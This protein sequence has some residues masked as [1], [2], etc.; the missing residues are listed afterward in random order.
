VGFN[1]DSDPM[2]D[3]DDNPN[4]SSVYFFGSLLR[5]ESSLAASR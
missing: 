1:P 2:P 3:P 5:P 4:N